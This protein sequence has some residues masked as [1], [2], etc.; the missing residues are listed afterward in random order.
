MEQNRHSH[1]HILTTLAKFPPPR[2][3]RNFSRSA[4]TSSFV[5]LGFIMP[6][7]IELNFFFF[8]FIVF[9]AFTGATVFC[10]AFLSARVL[11]FLSADLSAG[12][13]RFPVDVAAASGLFL[14]MAKELLLLVEDDVWGMEEA[15]GSEFDT[16][17]AAAEASFVFGVALQHAGFFGVGADS[18]GRGAAFGG[19][20]ADAPC[21][22]SADSMIFLFLVVVCLLACLFL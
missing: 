18:E 1:H 17:V 4:C 5:V 19:G 16:T 15:V 12:T 21:W 3:S 10:G 11:L 22:C 8:F 6:E 14:L 20:A 2:E 13:T 9:L 7:R